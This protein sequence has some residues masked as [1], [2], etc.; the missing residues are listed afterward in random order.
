MAIITPIIYLVT[1]VLIFKIPLYK[2]DGLPN[3]TTKKNK[4][5]EKQQDQV[6]ITIMELPDGTKKTIK[7]TID[8]FG[9]KTIEETLEAPQEE[10]EVEEE[11]TFMPDGSIKRTRI[12][13][14]EDGAKVIHET[15]EK[16]AQV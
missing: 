5:S 9:N 10:E 11:V 1:A 6:T 16:P 8:E 13:F 4:V 2:S 7:T 12:T 3:T 14:D 15:I